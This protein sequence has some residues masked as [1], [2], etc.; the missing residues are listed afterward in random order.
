MGEQVFQLH[1]A[2]PTYDTHPTSLYRARQETNSTGT[3]FPTDTQQGL[4]S[5]LVP[6]RIY[7]PCWCAIE[8]SLP[9]G[10]SCHL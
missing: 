9:A 8:S 7:F 5:L 4:L 10:A 1:V 6:K 2:T 3:S